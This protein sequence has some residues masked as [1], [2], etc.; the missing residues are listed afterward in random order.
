MV[1]RVRKLDLLGFI[2]FA[3]AI[4][5]LLLAVQWGGNAYPWRSARIIG[6]FCGAGGLLLVFAAWEWR[7]QDEASIPPKLLSQRSVF[8]GSVIGFLASGSLQLV[9]YYLPL[10]FQVIKGASPTKSG[11]M[12]LP[13]ILG[14]VILSVVAGGLGESNPLY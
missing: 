4:I 13:S 11:V 1:E 14:T 6:L 5:M 7:K 3:P 12:N 2:L 8:L 10:W 9:T